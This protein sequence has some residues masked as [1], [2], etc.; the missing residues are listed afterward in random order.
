MLQTQLSKFTEVLHFNLVICL[1][2]NLNLG[3]IW[4]I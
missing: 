1:V 2:W 4:F 3:L